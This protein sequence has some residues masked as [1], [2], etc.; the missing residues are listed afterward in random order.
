VSPVGPGPDYRQGGAVSIPDRRQRVGGILVFH[1]Q[2]VL[3]GYSAETTVPEHAG[4][5]AR[6][7]RFP[8]WMV[9]VALTLPRALAK[10][11]FAA[12][13]FHYSLFGASPGPGGPLLGTPYYMLDEGHV[14][15]ART[16]E[17]YKIAF[18][19]DE[20]TYCQARFRFTEDMGIDC[21]Y[22]CFEPSE[23]EKVWGAH[24]SV[25]DVHTTIP[26]YVDPGMAEA[27]RRFA[28]PD[29]E[30]EIDVGYRGRP[31]P[32]F[33]DTAQEKTEI[34]R[35]FAEL[36]GDSGLRLDIGLEES[37]RLYGEDW[38]R[39]LGGS[40]TMLG[41]ESG[42]S[43]VD[44]EDRVRR[45]Y[46]RLFL[47]KGEVTLE[48][49]SRGALPEFDNRIYYKTIAPRHF[50][51]AAFGAA[52][53]NFEGRYSDAMEPGVHYIPLAKDFSNLEEVLERIRDAGERR[54]VAEAA[55]R[56]LIDSGAYTYESFVAGFDRE[57]GEAGVELGATDT[58]K[59]R[60][61]R[62]IQRG[63]RWREARAKFAP[64]LSAAYGRT[65]A[66]ASGVR[67]RLGRR[68]G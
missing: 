15:F 24:T 6:H 55:R 13:V 38:Y 50:E 43:V 33:M 17:A 60:V 26:G 59:G 21:V 66:R 42:V 48:E 39:F 28:E 3:R 22:T 65:L 23:Y 20:H 45:D 41:V 11:D 30:R 29:A 5:F 25:S 7:S 58:E 10:F 47:E 62:A 40:R 31:M 61:R 14:E 16:S 32:I 57:L 4:S 27:G 52:Q 46:E 56:D 8:V 51:A 19:Q 12:I 64:E 63:H 44:T 68:S 18:F 9:N 54:R 37:D 36:A 2:P 34:G 35:R 1:Y 49:L 53:V 67:R